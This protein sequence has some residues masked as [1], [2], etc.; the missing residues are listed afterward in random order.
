[1]PDTSHVF[2]HSG[3]LSTVRIIN[4]FPIIVHFSSVDSQREK[5]YEQDVSDWIV[6]V[7]VIVTVRPV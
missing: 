1:M 2:V 4:Y 6:I 3:S 7:T 5:I